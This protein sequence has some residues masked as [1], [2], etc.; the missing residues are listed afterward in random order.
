MAVHTVPRY[1][2]SDVRLVLPQIQMPPL[3]G[4]T[5]VQYR[6]VPTGYRNIWLCIFQFHMDALLRLV[7]GDEGYTPIA[8]LWKKQRG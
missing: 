8:S 2:S 6:E 5:E 7:C 3:A 4:W 1:A